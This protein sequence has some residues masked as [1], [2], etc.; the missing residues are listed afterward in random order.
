[1]NKKLL[2]LLFCFLTDL[3]IHAAIYSGSCGDNVKYSL[4]T[5]TGVLKITGVGAMNDYLYVGDAPWYSKKSAIVSVEIYEGVTSVG[6][7]AFEGCSNITSV[8]LGNSITSIKKA[9]FYKCKSITS[10]IMGAGITSIEERAFEGC[11][12]KKVIW[13]TNTPPSGYTEIS[14]TINYVANNNY[15]N[16]SYVKVYPF[17]SSMFEIDGIRY[18]P[19]SPSERICDA[20]DCVYDESAE[21]ITIGESVTNKGISLKIQKIQPYL[22]YNNTYIKKVNIESGYKGDVPSYSFYGCTSIISA[23]I[24][25]QGNIEQKAFYNSTTFNPATFTITNSGNIGASAFESCTKI[26]QLIID[27]KGS[28]GESC[29]SDCTSLQTATLGNSISYIGSYAFNNCKT[30]ESIVIPNSIQALGKNAFNGCSSMTS[31]K[32]GN[33]VKIINESTFSGCSSLKK[34]EIGDSVTSIAAYAFNGCKN[35][36]E[37]QIPQNVTVIGNNVFS[38]CTGLKTVIM[39]DRETDGDLKLGYNGSNPLFVDCPLDSV[40]I[41]RNITYNTASN[42]GYSPFY[43]NTS[44]RSVTIT[45]KETEISANEFYGC[46]NLQNVKIGDGVT[47]I[48][49]WAFSGCS[50]LMNFSFGTQVKTIGQEAFS[51]CTAVT[52]ITSKAQ[53]PPT[54]GSQALDDINKW[55]CM[56]YVPEG[57]IADYQA[58]DQWKE[59]FFVEEGE[60]NEGSEEGGD[61]PIDPTDNRCATPNISFVDGKLSFSCETEGVE[62]V[63]SVIPPSA[64]SGKGNDINLSTTYRIIVYATKEGYLSSEIATKDID[65]HGFGGIRGDLNG[66]GV[67]NMPD[68]MFIVN[69]ILKDKFPDE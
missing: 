13:L 69:K 58:A 56:L 35:L 47:S 62:Y 54:C 68:A 10:V 59:F 44:L 24:N 18:V 19:V 2:L 41:G 49:N 26:S 33:G 20:I 28:I 51:D 55:E 6:I 60:E 11:E 34:V 36:P 29:F 39:A 67:V 3:I 48:G 46:T 22:C 31:A 32:I 45:D 61:T 16:L 21:N 64:I 38:G 25:N 57:H 27:N 37:I 23:D 9:A 52:A 50:S 17:L 65:V 63:Y 30:L 15:A 43:R 53:T 14:S 1:M 42:Y 5:E 12:T 40:Y 7:G 8:T 4:D 66:D